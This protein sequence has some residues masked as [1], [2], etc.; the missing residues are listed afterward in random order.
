MLEGEG[1]AVAGDDEVTGDRK[2]RSLEDIIGEVERELG[3][4]ALAVDILKEAPDKA[5]SIEP[6][7]LAQ[8]SLRDGSR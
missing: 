6:T 1:A 8:S 3:R 2:L 7:L 4:N 5:R